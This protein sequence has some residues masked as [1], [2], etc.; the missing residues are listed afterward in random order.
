[1]LFLE[2]PFYLNVHTVRTDNAPEL[3]KGDLLQFYLSKGIQLQNSCVST[4]QQNGVLQQNGVGEWKHR[5]ILEISRALFFQSKI[6][7]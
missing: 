2:N 5:H 4:P 3:S 6:P 7:I 1:M